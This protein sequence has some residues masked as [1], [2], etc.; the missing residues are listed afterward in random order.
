MVNKTLIGIGIILLFIVGEGLTIYAEILS[1]KRQS[2][3]GPFMEVF[4]QMLAIFIVAG[5]LLILGYMLGYGFFKNIWIISV[6]SIASIVIIEPILAYAIF[7]EFP[8]RGPLIGMIL[9][10]LGMIATLVL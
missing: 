3:N 5:I 2:Q 8:S 1:A 10:I 7:R 4:L 9:G 6:L